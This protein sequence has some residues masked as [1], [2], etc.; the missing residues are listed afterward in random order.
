MSYLVWNGIFILP[1]LYLLARLYFFSH[2]IEIRSWII[3]VPYNSMLNLLLLSQY[4][5]QYIFQSYI[6][7]KLE[8]FIK[9]L[10]VSSVISCISSF[11]I[12]GWK[13]SAFLP[14]PPG[15]PASRTDSSLIFIQPKCSHFHSF[16]IFSSAV[17]PLPSIPAWSSLITMQTMCVFR[18]QAISKTIFNLY[19]LPKAQPSHFI[20]T[21][22][23]ICWK[24]VF[25]IYIL[26]SES[27]RFW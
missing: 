10:I 18:F 24:I 7:A 2:T 17:L 20:Y 19:S 14:A 5:C 25:L 6:I 22:P 26:M 12:V 8:R 3:S 27:T 15:L 4:I 1:R 13:L 9:I 23:S 16:H 11:A 21:F